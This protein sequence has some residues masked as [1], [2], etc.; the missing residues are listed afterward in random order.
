M[1]C[2]EI[3]SLHLIKKSHIFSSHI[4]RK[5]CNFDFWKGTSISKILKELEIIIKQNLGI[6]WNISLSSPI[7]RNDNGFCVLI[8]LEMGHVHTPMQTLP[9]EHHLH[10][11]RYFL[12]RSQ[13]HGLASG[14]DFSQSKLAT[15]SN[16]AKAAILI[17]MKD[18]N[19]IL[20]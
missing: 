14:E 11:H 13:A 12:L 4:E 8:K 1:K 2:S 10:H 15:F 3:R 18:M 20:C 9:Q 16:L 17:I 7:R 19:I 5:L 6:P